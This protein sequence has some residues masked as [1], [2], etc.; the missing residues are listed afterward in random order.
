MKIRPFYPEDLL[1]CQH[2]ESLCFIDEQTDLQ[3]FLN[4]SISHCLV[5]EDDENIQGYLVYS[6]VADESEVFQLAVHPDKRNQ[7]YG[8]KLME[9]LLQELRVQAVNEVFLEVRASNLAAQKLYQN[10]G[11]LAYDLRKNYYTLK[12]TKVKEDA[13]LFKYSLNS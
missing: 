9:A 4:M 1:R 10:I 7:K 6:I 3:S 8:A 13:L 11:M 5:L 2:L 12:N